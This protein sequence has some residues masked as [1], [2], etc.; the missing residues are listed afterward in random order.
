MILLSKNKNVLASASS[1][2]STLECPA[3]VND[4]NYKTRWSSNGKDNK[5]IALDLGE[6][7]DISRIILQWEPWDINKS[8]TLQ[9][10]IDGKVWKNVVVE[11]YNTEPLRI[12]NIKLKNTRFIRM[13]VKGVDD[14]V[15]RLLEFEIW[16]KK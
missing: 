14:E 4:A 3:K 12:F 1:H 10:S 2:T 6:K 5:W 15:V 7:H 11:N 16:G 13:Y 8:F 9:T